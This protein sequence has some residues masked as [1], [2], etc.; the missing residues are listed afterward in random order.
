MPSL[1]PVPTLD[2]VVINARDR[3]DEAAELYRRLGFTLTPRGYHTLGSMNHLAM[4][5]TDYL[6]LIAAEAG[7]DRRPEIMGAPLGLNGLVFATE[8]AEE[9][10]E[11][12]L[13]AD[14]ATDPP[15][16]FSRPVEVSNGEAGSGVAVIA[17]RDAVF[18]TTQVQR[19]QTPAGR[20]YFCQHLTRDLVWR[21][22]W[23]HHANGAVG[24]ARA[25]IAAEQPGL[26]GGMFARMFGHRA[27]RP[28]DD[29]CSLILGLSR[30]DVVTPMALW[31]MFGEAAPDSRGRQDYMAALT[32]RTVSLDAVET[33]L[34]AGG[35]RGWDR[36][37]TSVLVPAREAFGVTLEFSV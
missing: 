14:V 8:D 27:V 20:F 3:I 6:E 28:A 26:L 1:F 12:L 10:Y 32:I 16:Q 37:G 34:E 36:I 22:A 18:R 15:R 33:A 11:R 30:F 19:A 13:R 29:G 17:R 31:E 25:V 7:D 9:I 5:G 2:H 35:I 23:R 24:V 21:D 4:F